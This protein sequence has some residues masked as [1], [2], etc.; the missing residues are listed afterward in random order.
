MEELCLIRNSRPQAEVRAASIVMCGPLA[1]NSA[2]VVFGSGIL[3]FRHSRLIVAIDRTMHSPAAFEQVSSRHAVQGRN[4]CVQFRGKRC[5]SIMNEKAVVVIAWE[6]CSQMLNHPL[7]GWVRSPLQC[8]TRRESIS[9]PRED[10]GLE[11][12]RKGLRR[13]SAN[14]P[15]ELDSEGP[16]TPSTWLGKLTGIRAIRRACSKTRSSR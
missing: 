10:S 16:E 3:K 1:N 7:S 6:R 14:H 5:V 13:Q 12:E 9:S 11:S 4:G 2:H 15:L 8:K